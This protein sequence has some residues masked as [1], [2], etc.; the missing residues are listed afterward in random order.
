MIAIAEAFF[1][2]FEDESEDC[3]YWLFSNFQK[4]LESYLATIEEMVRH[5]QP[6]AECGS[7]K[8]NISFL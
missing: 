4:K 5:S 1:L 2:L 3:R 6:C 8:M 7:I